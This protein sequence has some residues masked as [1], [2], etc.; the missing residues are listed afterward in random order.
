MKIPTGCT[1]YDSISGF[2]K[3]VTAL[4]T[5]EEIEKANG[6]R[7]WQGG[8]T[9]EE[10]F[11]LTAS[12]DTSAVQKANSIMEHV[13][14]NI[15]VKGNRPCWN[16]APAGA[17][18]NVPA[19]LANAPETMYQRQ[20]TRGDKR[21]I[22]I[23]YSPSSSGDI[24]ADKVFNRGVTV[25]ALAMQLSRTKDVNIHFF[26]ARGLGNH[27]VRLTAPM[28]LSESAHILTNVGFI[29][30]ISLR[31]SRSLGWGGNWA[32]WLD[33]DDDEATV[34]NIRNYYCLSDDDIIIP[35]MQ[36]RKQ[37]PLSNPVEYINNILKKHSL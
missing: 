3:D 25:L 2:L 24:N 20:N 26:T 33:R 12:G 8:S 10:A 37:D 15:A 29:R 11:A 35:P 13:D 17:F 4:T 16:T 18:P 34:K 6:K 1:Y 31:L 9:W 22:N 7:R 30:G 14:D 28:V 5:A 32:S 21:A 27:V 36:K 19:Y 23:F